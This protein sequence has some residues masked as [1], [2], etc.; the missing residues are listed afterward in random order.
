MFGNSDFLGI[1]L[2]ACRAIDRCAACSRRQGSQGLVSLERHPLV[3][4]DGRLCCAGDEFRSVLRL[5]P[6]GRGHSAIHL[7]YTDN[8]NEET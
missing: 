5:G 3:D 4:A 8:I 1:V 6:F 7:T 2:I